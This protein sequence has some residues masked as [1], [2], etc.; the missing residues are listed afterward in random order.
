MFD[1]LSSRS[2][3]S[4]ARLLSLLMTVLLISLREAAE[5]HFRM[6]HC[7]AVNP[8]FICTDTVCVYILLFL[9]LPV[10]CLPGTAHGL[11]LRPISHLWSLGPYVFPP[12]QD[13]RS[14]LLSSVSSSIFPFYWVVLSSTQACSNSVYSK[15]KKLILMCIEFPFQWLPHI[16]D[17]LVGKF[18]NI[19]FILV[20][21][22]FFFFSIEI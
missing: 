18:L 5:E 16:L 7:R 17:L 11:G 3:F 20:D 10:C 19:I 12:S 4:F 9:F 2:K 21:S 1:I 13:L 15:K 8:A 6:P 14:W 22:V